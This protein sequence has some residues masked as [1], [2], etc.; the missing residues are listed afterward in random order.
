M[1]LIVPASADVSRDLS[2]GD[3]ERV[4]RTASGEAASGTE[5]GPAQQPQPA[6]HADSSAT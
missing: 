3:L 1:H 2:A 5:N 4:A 6:P